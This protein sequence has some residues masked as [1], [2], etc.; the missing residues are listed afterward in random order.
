MSSPI[1]LSVLPLLGAAVALAAGVPARA[2]QARPAPIVVSVAASLADVMSDLARR[3]E[4][5]TG[6]PVR[7]NVGGSNFLARQIVEGASADVFVSADEAQMDVAEHAGRLVPGSRAPLLTNRLVVVGRPGGGLVV[8][9]AAALAG[10]AVR[11]VALGNPDSVPAGVYARRWLEGR[12]IWAQ[13]APKVVPT[14][15]VRAALAAARA[16]R[17]DAAVV[18]AT[19]A[20]TEPLLPVLLA[21][22]AGETPPIVYPVAVV[23]GRRQDAAARFVTFLRSPAAAAVFAAAGFGVVG[24]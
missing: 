6:Q 10:D 5:A 23:A 15:T 11:R 1:R 8:R 21:V 3:H 17:V 22:P 14:V 2:E 12:G 24:R 19:D 9:D 7:L 4:Q 18:Y 16:G 20:A 13:V